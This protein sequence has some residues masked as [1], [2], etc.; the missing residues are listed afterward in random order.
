MINAVY[1]A[2]GRRRSTGRVRLLARGAT[3]EQA[4]R[5]AMQLE[6]R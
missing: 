6:K 1:H 5:G 3:A 4:G 2:D